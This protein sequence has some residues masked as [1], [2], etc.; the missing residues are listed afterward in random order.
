[1]V[2]TVDTD[3]KCSVC[4]KMQ[5]E[6]PNQRTFPSTYP[7]INGREHT[8]YKR[9]GATQK[10]LCVRFAK[11]HDEHA[12][13]WQES[14]C[15]C[16]TCKKY[17]GVCPQDNNCPALV[18]VRGGDFGWGECTLEG[19]R[20]NKNFYKLEAAIRGEKGKPKP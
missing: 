20:L 18:N 7:I 13:R 9:S 17:G 3:K 14:V 6:H 4:G 12:R 10:A 8:I 5:S 19:K 16:F 11:H 1:M 2:R 15:S